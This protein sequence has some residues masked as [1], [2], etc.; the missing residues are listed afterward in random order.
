VRQVTPTYG[1]EGELLARSGSTEPVTLEYDGT[2]RLKVLRDGRNNATTYAYSL[3]GYLASVIFPGGDSTE[4]PLYDP[5]G[6]LRPL[7]ALTTH[8]YPCFTE[9]ACVLCPGSPAIPHPTIRVYLGCSAANLFRGDLWKLN[10]SQLSLA[11]CCQ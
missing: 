10:Y 6:N 11:A 2:Y 1:P 7:L 3:A 9:S 8:L 5:A 4:Y